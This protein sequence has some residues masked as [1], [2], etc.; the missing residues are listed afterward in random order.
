MVEDYVYAAY[1]TQL[2]QKYVDVTGSPPRIAYLAPKTV[3]EDGEYGTRV[4]ATY[5]FSDVKR[6]TDIDEALEWLA[7]RR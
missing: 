5:G 1:G 4:A 7:E 2:I 3:L 6:T